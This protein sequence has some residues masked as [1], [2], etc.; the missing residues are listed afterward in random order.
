MHR[1]GAV[2]LDDLTDPE[3][4]ASHMLSETY[5]RR[6]R[7]QAVAASLDTGTPADVRIGLAGDST[8]DAT[9]EWFQQFLMLIGAQFPTLRVAYKDWN[10]GA[11]VNVPSTLKEG[12][13]P[14]YS[15]KVTRRDTFART[16]ADIIGTPTEIGA[17]NWSAGGADAAGDWSADGAG[18]IASADTVRAPI[19][20][21]TG[22][23][24]SSRSRF[25]YRAV[26][27]AAC[28]VDLF[29]RRVN[30]ANRLYFSL[31]RPGNGQATVTLNRRVGGVTTTLGTVPAAPVPGDGV[32]AFAADVVVAV[33]GTAAVTATVTTTAGTS[34]LT[35]TL[36][37]A[38]WTA[39]NAGFNV[40]LMA[41]SGNPIGDRWTLFE[42]GLLQFILPQQVLTGY[43]GSLAGSTLDYQIDKVATQFP[44]PLDMLIV[45]SGHNY[46]TEAA[47]S[48][49]SKVRAYIAAVR[50]VHPKATILLSS[51]NPEYPPLAG[52]RIAAHIN[53][54][55]ALRQFAEANGY[56]YVPVI[57][58]WSAQP[59]PDQLVQG[60]GLHPTVG[61]SSGSSFWAS[62]MYAYLAQFLR[63]VA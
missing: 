42:F 1:G 8:G 9:D 45:S 51:Q 58:R 20:M 41:T 12:T 24:G 49:I 46:T 33:D 47:D 16:V 57:E 61:P 10:E 30:D 40:G 25:T 55:L 26:S 35:A 28:N 50:A 17:T 62:V 7:G 38:D 44:D 22:N 53:R 32:Y 48:Y 34:T 54:C 11:S 36:S 39:V 4:I 56:G 63:R 5:G 2:N 14:T 52:D 60:D 6:D 3:H 21:N 43:N 59:N 31:S 29:L 15:Y 19:L 18:A 23:V 13:G 27:T 37:A